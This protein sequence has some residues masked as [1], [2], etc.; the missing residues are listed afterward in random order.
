MRRPIYV[1]AWKEDANCP[2]GHCWRLLKAMYGLKDAGAAFDA[3]AESTMI[4]LGFTVG[5]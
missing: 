3:K 2:E 1:K 5:V 4:K